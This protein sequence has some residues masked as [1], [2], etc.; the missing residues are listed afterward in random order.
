MSVPRPGQVLRERWLDRHRLGS[1]G[2]ERVARLL[3]VRFDGR[4]R[5]FHDLDVGRGTIDHVVVG[6]TGVFVIRSEPWTG[7]VQLTERGR[8]TVDGRDEERAVKRVGHQAAA[9][10]RWLAQADL[11]VWIDPCIVLTHTSLPVGPIHRRSVAVLELEDLPAQITSGR[12][13]LDPDQIARAASALAM[14]PSAE[15]RGQADDVDRG[16]SSGVTSRP[17]HQARR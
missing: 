4:Y 10:R 8:L 13:W 11:D 6:P 17:A 7:R 5:A 3:E 14:R 2:E 12:T 16:G 9:M 1:D 15:G